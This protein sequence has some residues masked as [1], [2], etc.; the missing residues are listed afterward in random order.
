MMFITNPYSIG[1]LA[2]SPWVKASISPPFPIR[3]SIIIILLYTRLSNKVNK[4]KTT[5][6]SFLPLFLMEIKAATCVVVKT[7]LSMANLLGLKPSSH[8]QTAMWP[9]H[10]IQPPL[11]LSSFC[12]VTATCKENTV[13]IQQCLLDHQT[14]IVILR[15]VHCENFYL[16]VLWVPEK[17]FLINFTYSYESEGKEEKEQ[18]ERE[19]W[20]ERDREIR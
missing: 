10:A 3:Y 15:L 6:Q 7:K 16:S 17:I 2:P 18:G 12:L 1:Y 5:S 4:A 11:C 9:W 8:P 14:G 13:L 19:G 20:W